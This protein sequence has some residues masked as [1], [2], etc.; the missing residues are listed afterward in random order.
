MSLTVIREKSKI[1]HL[2]KIVGIILCFSVVAKIKIACFG[3]YSK[4]FKNA[5]NAFVESM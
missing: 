3:G 5:L 2:D 1:W 4:V